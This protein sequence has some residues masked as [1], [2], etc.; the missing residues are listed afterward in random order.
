MDGNPRE[1]IRLRDQAVQ[2]FFGR[3]TGVEPPS[4]RVFGEEIEEIKPRRSGLCPDTGF[5]L[6]GRC[7]R[8]RSG[9]RGESLMQAF[10]GAGGNSDSGSRRGVAASYGT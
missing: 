8:I 9:K 6:P 5:V 4:I 10:R 3:L 7:E 2:D 1:A